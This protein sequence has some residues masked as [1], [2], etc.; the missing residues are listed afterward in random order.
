MPSPP[1][2]ARVK[3]ASLAARQRECVDDVGAAHEAAVD[4]YLGLAVHRFHDFRQHL[5]APQPMVE[6][7]AAMV[8]DIDHLDAV[9]DRELRVLGGGNALDDER[10]VGVLVLE[11]LHLPPGERGLERR[12]FDRFARQGLTKRPSRSRSRRLYIATSTVRQKAQKPL[13]RARRAKS[14]TQASSPRT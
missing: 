5:C 7:P 13:S 6:L 4:P 9:L 8:G 2:A 10:K 14:S 11:A 1:R 12:A 3:G